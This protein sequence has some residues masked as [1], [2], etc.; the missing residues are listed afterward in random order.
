MKRIKAIVVTAVLVVTGFSVQTANATVEI[1]ESV[2]F[3]VKG[4]SLKSKIMT[5][6][7]IKFIQK[8]VQANPYYTY[9]DC[10]VNYGSAVSESNVDKAEKLADK[11][12][13]EIEKADK[14]Y[15]ASSDLNSSDDSISPKAIEIYFSLEDPRT[16]EYYV[17]EASG[18]V[19]TTSSP[20]LYNKKITV[21]AKPESL[22]NR[23]LEFLGWTAKP[24]GA[25][26]LYLPS[27]K[28][29]I[30]NPKTLYAKWAGYNI[31]V[32]V[33]DIGEIGLGHVG[34]NYKSPYHNN[35]TTE[36]LGLVENQAF[37]VG[38]TEGTEQIS[39]TAPGNVSSESLVSTGDISATYM[40]SAV[41]GFSLDYQDCTIWQLTATGDGTL[42]YDVVPIT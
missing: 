34:F 37:E 4:L 9:G 40:G 2:S 39:F 18:D 16:L 1:P 42:T 3:K 15:D 5:A 32:T 22:E 38:G 27:S 25:G 28:I 36:L 24:D 31:D 21:S 10:W 30:K 12:C 17:G 35:F 41:C 33:I 8:K 6:K 7:Q 29:A 14:H 13:R 23:G 20:V 19:P 26:K 11:V